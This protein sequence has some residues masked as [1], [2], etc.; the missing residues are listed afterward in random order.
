MPLP[1]W[2]RLPYRLFESRSRL[3]SVSVGLEPGRAGSGGGPTEEHVRVARTVG[4]VALD[5]DDDG[6]CRC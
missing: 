5:G 3:M 6:C 1:G 4:A 2:P